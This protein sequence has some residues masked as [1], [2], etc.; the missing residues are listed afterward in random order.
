MGKFLICPAEH[1][2]HNVFGM[3]CKPPLVFIPVPYALPRPIVALVAVEQLT[4]LPVQLHALVLGLFASVVAPFGGFFASGIKRAYGL[5]DFAALIP[6]HGANPTLTLTLTLTLALVLTL[7]LSL[8]GGP[9]P[10]SYPFS[11]PY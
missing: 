1:M 6:G 2:E 7:T 8:P 9:F 4:L 11:Y 5:N 3:D 10:Y